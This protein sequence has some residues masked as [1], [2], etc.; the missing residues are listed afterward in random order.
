VQTRLLTA[1]CTDDRESVLDCLYLGADVNYASQ[2][3]I[4]GLMWAAK[5]GSCRILSVLL[6]EPKLRINAVDSD[7]DTALA[8][9]ASNGKTEVQADQR[10]GP[11]GFF[12]R[13][14]IIRPVHE[15]NGSGSSSDGFWAC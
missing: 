14:W 7:G 3:G 9:A 6:D 12:V 13:P 8:H 10:Y 1:C 2:D 4:S 15:N 11:M 5:E